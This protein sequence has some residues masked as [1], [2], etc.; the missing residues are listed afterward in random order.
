MKYLFLTICLTSI[1]LQIVNGIRE[2]VV[3]PFV[4]V[5]RMPG[6]YLTKIH[7]E[8]G[9]S[10]VTLAFVLGGA[11]GCDPQW[12]GEGGIDNPQILESIHNFQR[13]GGKVILATG[14]AMGPY[15][16]TACSSPNA[17]SDAYKKALNTVGSTHLD[18]DIEASVSL[19]IMNEALQILQKQIP[20]LTISFTLMIQGDDYGLT[21]VLGVEVLRNADKHGV[22][23]DIVNAMTMEYGTKLSDWG[24]A[25]IAAAESVHNQMKQIWP[26]KSN[27]ELYAMLGIT[28]MIGRNFNGK[29]FQIEHAKRLVQWAKTKKI[30]HLAFWSLGRDN[31]NCAGGGVSPDCSSI[32]QGDL[33]FTRIFQQYAGTKI[34]P[35][36]DDPHHHP[37]TTSNPPPHEKTTPKPHQKIDCSIENAHYP[38]ETECAKY[39]WCYNGQPHLETC[40]AGT[41]WDPKINGCNFARDAHRT[42]CV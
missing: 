31:G 37:T 20:D 11:A 35:T 26:A 21:D 40:G 16:E 3:A 17:L 14:G 2:P 39:Y 4:D 32:A 18:I 6:D 12:G 5:T 25:V 42:D 13:S 22:K 19:D 36:T 9:L 33:E 8:T 38:H 15:L 27:E 30:G 7:K 28:P 10:A 29:I 23:V 24:E 41:V 1:G 34:D